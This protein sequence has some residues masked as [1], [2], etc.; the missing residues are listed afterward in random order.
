MAEERRTSP[1]TPEPPRDPD[2][3]VE[4]LA[5]RIAEVVNSAG[6][7]QR[8]VLRE[9]AVELLK[10]ETELGDAPP[11][12]PKATRDAGSNPLGIALLLALVSLPLG[13]LFWPVGLT[14][15]AMAA[16]MGLWGV[17]A[18]VVRR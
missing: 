2:A 6:P 12:P 15:L 13:L 4:A 1:P 16:V 10:E 11:A 8:S 17:I 14:M 3:Q 9:Y 5:R 18:T 7:E